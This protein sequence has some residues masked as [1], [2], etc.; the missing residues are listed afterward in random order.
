MR[1]KWSRVGYTP[2]MTTASFQT[3]ERWHGTA[4][5]PDGATHEQIGRALRSIIETEGP[6]QQ[7]VILKRYLDAA[8]V[9]IGRDQAVARRVLLEVLQE[10]HDDGEVESTT[11]RAGDSFG[12]VYRLPGSPHVIVRRRGT[13]TPFEVPLSELAAAWHDAATDDLDDDAIVALLTE[14][15][16]F[17]YLVDNARS[18]LI[19]AG[20][21]IEK[22][23]VVQPEEVVAP[24]A[25]RYV[26]MLDM[27]E[28]VS[29]DVTP[30]A[31]PAVE[32]EQADRR[33]LIRERLA[34]RLDELDV[35]LRL[36]WELGDWIE[37]ASSPGL[38]IRVRPGRRSTR[39]TAWFDA[40]PGSA[41]ENRE[42][43]RACGEAMSASDDIQVEV[44]PSLLYRGAPVTLVVDAGFHGVEADDIDE[45]CE[46]I[47]SIAQP[48]LDAVREWWATNGC[49]TTA[50]GHMS[51][52]TPVPAPMPSEVNK[53]RQFA[54][55]ADKLGVRGMLDQMYGALAG[56][57]RPVLDIRFGLSSVTDPHEQL[58]VLRD[59][60]KSGELEQ[61]E[62]QESDAIYTLLRYRN[63][64]AHHNDLKRLDVIRAADAAC[65]LV[66]ALAPQDVGPFQLLRF[67]ASS[68]QVWVT[69]K[70]LAGASVRGN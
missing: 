15:F 10:L 59:A 46:T 51:Q 16:G 57:L 21:H 62:K 47:A 39:V 22:S 32:L 13:R 48:F 1:S 49:S 58:K 12:R 68:A 69:A 11:E 6:I 34:E 20:R 63:A 36:P 19:D 60:Y 14:K 52:S 38:Q 9:A 54:M 56:V 3:Y 33:Q 7:G 66:R 29:G 61:L 8:G 26:S 24:A 4:P 25:A 50:Q 64:W 45:R 23:G 5:D 53:I 40:G 27:L 2:T 28:S 37:Y 41:D 55:E 67:G 18:R 31:P 42:T 65:L 70:Q 30:S 35:G 43:A 17:S 44:E